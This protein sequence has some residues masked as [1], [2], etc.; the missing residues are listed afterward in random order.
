ADLPRLV[1]S[2]DIETAY[3]REFMFHVAL[4]SGVNILFTT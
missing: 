1:A 3:P 2:S 4:P